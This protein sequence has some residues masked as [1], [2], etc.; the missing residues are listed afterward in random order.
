VL[1]IR[2][3]HSNGTQ[4]DGM[5]TS[6]HTVLWHWKCIVECVVV[7]RC[8]MTVRTDM[9]VSRSRIGSLLVVVGI[10]LLLDFTSVPEY[11]KISLIHS[12]G[13]Q[14]T[15]QKALNGT[16][17]AQ[18][19]GHVAVVVN[20][21]S[22]KQSDS[23]T[24]VPVT[25][26][27]LI[28][29]DPSG[30][31]R[32]ALPV[33]G[34][35]SETEATT[36]TGR[37]ILDQ[38][39]ATN[40]ADETATRPPNP[41]RSPFSSNSLEWLNGHRLSNQVEDPSFVLSQILDL[42]SALDGEFKS[43]QAISDRSICHKE[44]RFRSL[45]ATNWNV[46]DA[47][48]VDDWTFRLVFLA[49]HAWHHVPAATEAK[50]RTK[51]SYQGKSE[52]HP[53]DIKPFDYECPT[54]KFLITSMPRMGMGASFRMGA[55]NAMLMGIAADRITL[56]LNN[57]KSNK[58]PA[59]QITED[60][61]LASCDRMDMQCSFLPTSPCV[62]T[63]EALENETI[64]IPETLAR[65]MR[66]R[67]SIANETMAAHRYLYTDSRLNPVRDKGIHQ[68]VRNT[69]AT[70]AA[71]IIA[72]LRRK[73]QGLPEEKFAVLDQALEQL[74]HLAP[75]VDRTEGYTYQNR[76]SMIHHAALLYLLRMQRGMQE[77][78]EGQANKIL[79]QSKF[80]P[81]LAIG[82]PIRGSDKCFTETTCLPFEN[83]MDLANEVWSEHFAGHDNGS[84]VITTE[85]TD[86]ANASRS[87]DTAGNLTIVM[88]RDDI[89][90]D[91]GRP[92][93]PKYRTQADAIMEST[94]V[95]IKLQLHTK[96]TI[97]NC[98]SNFHLVLFDLLMEGCGLSETQQ[99]LQET[100]NPAYHVCCQWTN[101]EECNSQF[102]RNRPK[103]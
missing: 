90:Q 9:H 27:E 18:V 44:G 69:L 59:V 66:R 32:Q 94:L 1:W 29:S 2:P 72:T 48:L 95:A 35:P 76:D 34:T 65:H 28:M 83:Y 33:G 11:V 14:E 99:C 64:V 62:I 3:S 23:D 10:A 61:W 57:I 102:G 46:T 80:N 8:E 13:M 41:R 17:T 24:D 38:L 86:I 75:H 79:M 55:V 30:L 82:L 39:N 31:D 47:K 92:R 50:K 25:D 42:D 93:T 58:A 68:K 51:Y 56:F 78:V 96:F 88:N 12:G 103:L 60:F 87:Y 16:S 85:A 81:D 100:T 7:G 36:T 53:Y 40:E 73:T 77:R 49:L 54:A 4:T 15:G 67:G 45:S 63:M 37:T 89:L 101:T 52:L 74:R 22:A 5:A 84:V 26:I 19:G 21:T 91:T 70:Q 43:L 20:D 98:C 71:S 6:Y 97:G